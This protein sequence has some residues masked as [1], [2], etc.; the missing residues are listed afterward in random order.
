[1]QKTHGRIVTDLSSDAPQPS[2]SLASVPIHHGR[3][4]QA[5]ALPFDTCL[6]CHGVTLR[7][8]ADGPAARPTRRR[9]TRLQASTSFCALMEP[10]TK[11]FL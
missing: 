7:G 6:L 1:M 8:F 9:N 3:D 2:P 10:Q 5:P 4:A 11:E